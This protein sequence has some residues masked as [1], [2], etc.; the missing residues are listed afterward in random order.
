MLA[1]E[2]ANNLAYGQ[3]LAFEPKLELFTPDIQKCPRL[4]GKVLS[5]QKSACGHGQGFQA[6][7]KVPAATRGSA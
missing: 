3:I 6:Y 4:G 5:E 2:N 7:K 1:A